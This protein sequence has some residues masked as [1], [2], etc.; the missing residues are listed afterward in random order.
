MKEELALKHSVWI[1]KLEA[2]IKKLEQKI[3][4]LE[5]NKLGET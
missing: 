4:A 2:R 1:T 5:C 3:N